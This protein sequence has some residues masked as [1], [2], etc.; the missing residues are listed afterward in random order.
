MRTRSLLTAVQARLQPR[1]WGALLALLAVVLGARVIVAGRLQVGELTHLAKAFLLVLVVAALAPVPWQWTGDRRRM[2]GRLRGLT[3]ALAWNGLWVG[4]LVAIGTRVRP[5]ARP[6]LDHAASGQPHH[7]LSPTLGSFCFLVV[8]TLGVGWLVARFQAAEGDRAEA[9]EGRRTLELAAR[10][11]QEQALKAQLD[12]HVLY[13]ALSGIAELIREDPTRAEEA[14]LD[15]AEL[16]RQLTAMGRR[17]TVSLGEERALVTRYLALE[18]LRL[19]PRLRVAW[20]WPEALDGRQIPPLLMQPLVEN[21]IKHGLAP[22]KGGGEVRLAVTAE[23]PGLCLRVM[24]DGAAL[25]PD[26]RQGTGLANLTQRLALLGGGS[27]LEL[28]QAG[29][30][31][32]AELRLQPRTGS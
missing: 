27:S 20:D 1:R 24:N 8:L 25:N 18:A 22:S 31:T 6:A 5:L 32:V 12:P 7:G 26:W 21:A 30:W 14:L 11:A 10:E 29:T 28:T 3:Q 4:L 15:L 23:G 16:Y 9:M 17:A 13:N 2:A 19:G